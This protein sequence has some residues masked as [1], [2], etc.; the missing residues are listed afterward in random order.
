MPITLA[1]AAAAGALFWEQFNATRGEPA[2][3]AVGQAQCLLSVGDINYPGNIT[4]MR[5]AMK[6]PTYV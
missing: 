2:A 5:S 3:I 6:L 4:K 1:E